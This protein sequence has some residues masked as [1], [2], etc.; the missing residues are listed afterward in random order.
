LSDGLGGGHSDMFQTAVYSYTRVNA[1]YVAAALAYAWQGETTGRF[2]SVP[3]GDQLSAGF[4]ANNVGGRVEGGYRF[5]IPGPFGWPGLGVIPYAAVQMQAFMTPAYSESAAGGAS[6]FALAYAAQTTTVTRTELG[7]WLDDAIVLDNGALLALRTR[8]A[9]GHDHWSD[10]GVAAAFQSLPGSGF[11][12]FGAVPLRD[13]LLAS[14]GAEIAF[15][16]GFSIACLLDTELGS[17]SQTYIE[18]VR[19]RYSW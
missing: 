12:V 1:A 18:S 2:V 3:G 14:V 9:W 19:V 5:G 6:N 16:N 13:S 10:L 11:T 4:S 8:A 7:A 15:R 17:G